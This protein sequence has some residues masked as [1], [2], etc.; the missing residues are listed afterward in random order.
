M[1]MRWGRYRV[2]SA[3]QIMRSSCAMIDR[4]IGAIAFDASRKISNPNPRRSE[5]ARH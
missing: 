5:R 3:R 1:Q 2:K 4:R